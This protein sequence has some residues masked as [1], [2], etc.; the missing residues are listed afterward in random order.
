MKNKFKLQLITE[1]VNI[2]RILLQC[3]SDLFNSKKTQKQLQLISHKVISLKEKYESTFEKFKVNDNAFYDLKNQ[4]ENSLTTKHSVE[5]FDSTKSIFK[6]LQQIE[7]THNFVLS[8]TK[9]KTTY[10]TV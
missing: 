4:L 8:K 5:I 3:K 10:Q 9:I 2:Y 1:Y 7:N 6:K